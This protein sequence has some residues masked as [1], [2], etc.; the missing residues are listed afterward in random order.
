MIEKKVPMDIRA[1]KT[2]VFGPLT[3]RQGLVLFVLVGIDTF[4]VVKVFLP[5]GV[6]YEYMVYLIAFIDA[7]FALIGFAAPMGIP[8]EKYAMIFIRCNLASPAK[9]LPE[10]IIV[11]PGKEEGRKRGNRKKLKKKDYIKHPEYI[12]HK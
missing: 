9:R 3:L 6:G 10:N 11:R 8:F 1:Y 4:L 7:P 12:A 5:L 2:K